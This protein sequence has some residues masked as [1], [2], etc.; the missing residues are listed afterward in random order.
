MGDICTVLLVHILM[1]ERSLQPL[2]TITPFECRSCQH[3]DQMT[4]VEIDRLVKECGAAIRLALVKHGVR[5][6]DDGYEMHNIII[7]KNTSQITELNKNLKVE[8]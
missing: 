5:I 6:P 4:D 1:G 2:E 7:G 8:D 3:D